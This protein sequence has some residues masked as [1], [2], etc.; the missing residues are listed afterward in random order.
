V[1]SHRLDTFKKSEI[2]K[3]NETLLDALQSFKNELQQRFKAD[4]NL[5][6]VQIDDFICPKCRSLI[7][8]L[9]GTFKTLNNRNILI[10]SIAKKKNLQ[11][12]TIYLLT[13]V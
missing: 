3:I 11:V 8:R 9:R 1:C 2:K 13:L 7:Y 12:R 6:D 5:N 10:L 4:N